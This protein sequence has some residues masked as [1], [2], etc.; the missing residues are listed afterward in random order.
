M[1]VQIEHP[2]PVVAVVRGEFS[3]EEVSQK[4]D[5]FIEQIRREVFIPGFRPGRAPKALIKA[6]LGDAFKRELAGK[7]VQE[8]LEKAV[9]EEPDLEKPLYIDNPK[10]DELDEGKPFS[11]EIYIETKPKVELKKYKGF[12]LRRAPV[13]VTDEEIDEAI[14]SFLYRYGEFQERERPVQEGDYVEVKIPLDG[15]PVPILIPL[16]DPEY[17]QF[18]KPLIS[19][20][21]GDRVTIEA[22]F[23]E[24]FPDRRLQGRG[25]SF[26]VEITRVVE[27][28]KPTLDEEFLQKRLGKPEGYTKDDFRKEVADYIRQ[29]KLKKAEEDLRDAVIDELVKA[30]PVELP[31]KYVEMRAQ[32]FMA[33]T[34]DLSRATDEEIKRLLEEIKPHVERQ[35]AFEFIAE[36][37]AEAEGIEISES[38]A[39][40][41]L[42]GYSARAGVDFE[43]LKRVATSDQEGFSLLR[44]RMLRDKVVAKVL[45]TCRIVESEPQEDEKKDE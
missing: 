21:K 16:D 4:V 22:E 14:D 42:R 11:V 30:N 9:E 33:K 45:E 24:N 31:P 36:A 26:E 3:A 15:E 7:L 2:S 35:V 40:D 19:H 18:F 28:V 38:E 27:F 39:D 43:T 34:W 17:A 12:E 25:G 10:H 37:I 20:S 8:V 5:D 44:S 13:P 41:V 6:R 1:E 32:E 29:Q 23:P